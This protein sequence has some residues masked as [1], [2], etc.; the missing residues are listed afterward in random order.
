M[1]VARAGES[2][3]DN[4]L[5]FEREA[6][7]PIGRKLA[8]SMALALLAGSSATNAD[9]PDHAPAHGWRKQHDPDY[10]G[11][12]GA[13]WDRDYDIRAGGCDREAVGA[14]VGGVVGG[15]VGAHVGDNRPLA[16]L[17]GV[18]AGALIGAKIAHE[19]DE[20]D[21]G[22]F[23]HALEIGETGHR[24][25]WTNESIGVRYE[26]V[27]GRG[28]DRNGES[29][30]EFTFVTVSAGKKSSQSGLACRSEAAAWQI[31]H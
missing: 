14:V 2:G 6:D 19:I 4:D 1:A 30:R 16:T 27:P 13:H 7:M 24:V 31:V 11:Y 5:P 15:A 29:C 21:R 23:G 28:R 8:F 25:V 9:P 18:V 22:C 20:V 17:I 12:T 3:T 10:V 26:L